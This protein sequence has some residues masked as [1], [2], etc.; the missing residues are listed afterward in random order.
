M[1]PRIIAL[2]TLSFSLAACGKTVVQQVEGFADEAC[3]CKD[4]AC[5]E[6]VGKKMDDLKSKVEKPADA[7]KPALE[8]AMKRMQKCV[9]TIELGG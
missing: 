1:A 8:A 5:I 7:D 6:A 9:M 4:K 2:I 3:A